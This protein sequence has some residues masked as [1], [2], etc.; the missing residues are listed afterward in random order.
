MR[1]S[2][3]KETFPSEKRVALIPSM[4]PILVKQGL[5]SIV[6]TGVA[7]SGVSSGGAP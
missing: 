5:E 1:V 6:E 7:D 3:A 4:V 2:V